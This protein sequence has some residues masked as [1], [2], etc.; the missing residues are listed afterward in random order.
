MALFECDFLYGQNESERLD[1]A[2]GKLQEDYRVVTDYGPVLVEEDEN[3]RV[4]LSPKIGNKI[5]CIAADS[6]NDAPANFIWCD[7]E[8][9]IIML[10]GTE[11]VIH[12]K[13]K[14]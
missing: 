4:H 14:Q 11:Y 5:E 3:E 13:P 8:L 12:S 10:R 6:P 9:T 7:S 2:I 1:G